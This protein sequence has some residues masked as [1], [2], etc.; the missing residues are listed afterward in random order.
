MIFLKYELKGLL[1]F[2][3]KDYMSNSVIDNPYIL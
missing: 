1:E 2:K 3:S